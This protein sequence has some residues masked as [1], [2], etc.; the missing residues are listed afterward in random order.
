[1]ARIR[2]CVLCGKEYEYC[3]RCDTTKPTFYFKYCG[4]NCN[5]VAE[6]LN[7]FQFGHYNQEYAAMELMKCDLKMTEYS[8]KTRDYIRNILA[9][10][11]EPEPEPVVDEPVV[12]A[13]VEQPI[14]QP[15]EEVKPAPAS[16]YRR[17]TTKRK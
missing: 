4:S 7:K 14:E 9:V 6:I 17:S 3:P 13:E 12:K 15:I 5:K 8:D 1:M 11:R 16:R 2:K 10:T